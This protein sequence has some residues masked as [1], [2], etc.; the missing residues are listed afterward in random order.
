VI[1]LVLSIADPPWSQSNPEPRTTQAH[2][3]G[4]W[5]NKTIAVFMKGA[6]ERLHHREYDV[7]AIELDAAGLPPGIT[8]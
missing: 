3:L 7:L 1:Y 6:A 2:V 4:A 5:S 8:A